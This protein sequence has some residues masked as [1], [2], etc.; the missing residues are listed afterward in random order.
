MCEDALEFGH[1]A[2]KNQRIPD[3]TEGRVQN[4]DA[5]HCDA[6]TGTLRNVLV[7]GCTEEYHALRGCGDAE[8]EDAQ[9]HGLRCIDGIE[10]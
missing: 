3:E 1:P 7:D 10:Q 6:L 5:S 4:Y 9:K 2:P 8:V